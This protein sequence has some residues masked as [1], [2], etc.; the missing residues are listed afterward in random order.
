MADATIKE[1]AKD[2]INNLPDDANWDEIMY[3]IYVRQKI[4]A[5]LKDVEAGR[6]VDLKTIRKKFGLY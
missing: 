1:Q 4:E 2:L 3:E 6:T 5:G